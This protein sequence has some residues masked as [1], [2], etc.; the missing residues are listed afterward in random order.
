MDLRL[1]VA[2]AA[3]FAAVVAAGGWNF[4]G[5]SSGFATTTAHGQLV[6][7]AASVQPTALANGAQSPAPALPTP[8][9][10][11]NRD[12]EDSRDAGPAA[13]PGDREHEQDD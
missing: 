6:A 2:A 5:G 8:A 7:S 11:R 3:I 4:R 10:Q 12:R 9:R 1:A 13:N